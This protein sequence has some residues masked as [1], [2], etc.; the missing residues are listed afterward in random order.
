MRPSLSLALRLSTAAAA[1][2]LALVIAARPGIAADDAAAGQALFKTK[3]TACHS[4]DADR[5]GPRLQNVVGRPV[6]SVPTYSYSPA[7]KKLGGAWTPARLDQ[8]LSGTQKMAPGSKM[9][10]QVDDPA[11]R[12]L[13]IA[14]LQSVS[15]PSAPAA[16]K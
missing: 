11:Q 9:Y 7:L 1:G 5:I 4:V 10:L 6:A 2:V 13:I 16:K 3:C 8:W 14:Y 12:R 15:E